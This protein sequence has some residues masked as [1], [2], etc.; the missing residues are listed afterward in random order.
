MLI[1]NGG[2]NS[3]AWAALGGVHTIS[4][5]VD[6]VN[7]IAES[8]EENNSYSESI[9]VGNPDLVVT[10]IQWTPE[11]P[12]AGEQVAF[13]VTVKNQ[14]VAPTSE[15]KEFRIG[16]SIDNISNVL[17]K[18]GY[19]SSIAP[20]Q[21]V[22]LTMN[23]DGSMWTAVKGKHTLAAVVDMKNSIQ[24]SDEKNNIYCEEM[25]AIKKKDNK[26]K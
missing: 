11:E 7:R 9:T 17:W 16:L 3:A 23:N 20:G 22:I 15:G 21:S 25:S 19:A 14:G 18:C 10:G 8:N 12:I 6:D 4:A 26:D 2:T 13:K 5:T 24:E 1:V